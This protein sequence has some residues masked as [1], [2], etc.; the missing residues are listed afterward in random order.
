MIRIQLWRARGIPGFMV[1]RIDEETGCYLAD[2]QNSLLVQSDW[3]YPSLARSF[4]WDWRSPNCDHS[5]TD[6]T[7]TCECGMTASNFIQDAMEYLDA[8]LGKIVEDCDYFQVQKILARL[9]PRVRR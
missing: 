3:D 4:G 9:R 7:V 5:S 8:N 2:E 6:G 1:H